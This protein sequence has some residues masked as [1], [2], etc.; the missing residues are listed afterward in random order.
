MEELEKANKQKQ[1]E[2][3]RQHQKRKKARPGQ[4]AGSGQV[5]ADEADGE[6]AAAGDL[7]NPYG[8]G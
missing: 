2:Y 6:G 4:E 3:E 8:E 5:V 1:Q 7:Q